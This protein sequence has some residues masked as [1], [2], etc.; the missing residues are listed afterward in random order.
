MGSWGRHGNFLEKAFC[1]AKMDFFLFQFPLC[2]SVC[3]HVHVD[4]KKKSD[5][6]RLLF[7]QCLKLYENHHNVKRHIQLNKYNWKDYVSSLF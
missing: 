1:L 2:V 3:M 5:L 6:I 4:V 7:L